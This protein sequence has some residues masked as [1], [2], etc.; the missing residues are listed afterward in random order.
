M[1]HCVYKRERERERDREREPIRE[2]QGVEET[3]LVG[4]RRIEGTVKVKLLSEKNVTWQG[5]LAW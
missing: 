4:D 1:K 3:L 2:N 5:W